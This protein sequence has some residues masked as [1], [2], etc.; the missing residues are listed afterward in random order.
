MTEVSAEKE[1]Y[2]NEWCQKCRHKRLDENKDPCE[3]CLTYGVNINSHKPLKFE[4]GSKKNGR[5]RK[6]QKGT[7]FTR[8]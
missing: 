4:G 1:V 2:F 7:D 3:E 8:T 6:R 5:T